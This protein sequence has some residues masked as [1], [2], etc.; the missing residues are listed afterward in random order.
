LVL[1]AEDER[2]RLDLEPVGG[3]APLAGDGI[4]S[5]DHDLLDQL[6]APQA[7]E[8]REDLARQHRPP[9]GPAVARWPAERGVEV[10]EEGG[11]G[12]LLQPLGVEPAGRAQAGDHGHAPVHRGLDLHACA[13]EAALVEAAPDALQ[14][15]LVGQE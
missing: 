1:E 14:R 11:D 12:V 9:E 3:L 6:G 13:H 2:M 10:A 4:G 15:G 7:A 5:E 8:D